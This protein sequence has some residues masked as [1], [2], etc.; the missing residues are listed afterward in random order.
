ALMRAASSVSVPALRPMVRGMELP[1]SCAQERLWF[2]HQWEPES[3]WYNVPIALRLSGSLQLWAL[4]RSLSAVVQRHEVLRTT[5]AEHVGR[6]VQ[7]IAPCGA[8]PQATIQIP[9][10]DLRDWERTTC[11][12]QVTEL[13]RLE[14]ERSSDLS[15]DPLLR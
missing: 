10:I 9:V 2:L 5:F 14:A 4:Q 3:S 7:V 11:E 15:R 6:P 12:Q 1:L 8:S 13:V